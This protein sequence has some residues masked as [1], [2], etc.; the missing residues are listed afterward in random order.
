MFFICVVDF[1]FILAWV[2]FLFSRYFALNVC[3]FGSTVR[4]SQNNYCNFQNPTVFNKQQFS[5][6]HINKQVK[7]AL[8]LNNFQICIL[9]SCSP[10]LMHYRP[11]LI[12]IHVFIWDQFIKIPT[13]TLTT[14]LVTWRLN[15]SHF[16]VTVK[17]MAT[18]QTYTVKW[19]H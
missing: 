10:F 4:N 16:S 11:L 2:C 9:P 12:I 8:L 7:K 15:C 3:G 13:H 5:L 19:L 6:Q 1:C 14:D 17:S 18:Y